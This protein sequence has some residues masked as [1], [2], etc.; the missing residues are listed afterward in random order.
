MVE[1][2]F[3]RVGPVVE[4]AKVTV[5]HVPMHCTSIVLKYA[6]QRAIAV[7]ITVYTRVYASSLKEMSCNITLTGSE[8]E[9]ADETEDPPIQGM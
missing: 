6:S 7:A 3:S 1:A 9:Y 4:L 8:S 5:A 2:T